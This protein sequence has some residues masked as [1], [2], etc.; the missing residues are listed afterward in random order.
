VTGFPSARLPTIAFVILV[1]GY[2]LLARLPADMLA[3]TVASASLGRLHAADSAGTLWQGRADLR[4]VSARG[5]AARHLFTAHWRW[6]PA[7]LRQGELSWALWLDQRPGARLVLRS[8]GLQIENL[9]LALPADALE[10]WLAGPLPIRGLAGRMQFKLA[11]LRCGWGGGDCQGRLDLEWQ[12]ARIT[13]VSETTLGSYLGELE[14]SGADAPWNF[15]LATLSG[16]LRLNLNGSADSRK[17]TLNG[18]AAAAAE[19]PAKL[20]QWLAALGP[21]QGDGVRINFSIPLA[22]KVGAGGAAKGT[23]S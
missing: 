14:R 12:G 17:A 1:G 4:A 13:S 23:A 16:A 7:R 15:K 9:A 3:R 2:A 22:A 8:D 5:G 10:P 6:Q 18:T 20:Q 21:R 11:Q 19:A